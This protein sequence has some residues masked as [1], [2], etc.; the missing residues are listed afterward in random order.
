MATEKDNVNVGLL[1]AI[2]VVLTLSVLVIA[3]GVT[4]LV[5]SS[6]DEQVAEKSLDMRKPYDEMKS[7]QQGDL[8]A[9]AAWADKGKG[10]A[11]VPIDRAMELVVKGVQAD[12]GSATAPAPPPKPGADAGDDAAAAE[13]DGGEAGTEAT[14]A[15][16]P[17]TD[18]AAAAS[19]AAPHA[20]SDAA[21]AATDSGAEN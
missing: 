5:R 13:T 17:D 4:A 14:D 12:P 11:S 21:P 9:A 19:D 16:A 2:A 8:A 6:E 20:A 15:G 10:T 3:L 18:A 7:Q 1:G